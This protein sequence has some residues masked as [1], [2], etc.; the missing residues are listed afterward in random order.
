[1]GSEGRVEGVRFKSVIH[2]RSE[3]VSRVL[4]PVRSVVGVQGSAF[5]LYGLEIEFSRS[6]RRILGFGASCFG[7][8][9]TPVASISSL[10]SGAL[11]DSGF[12]IRVSGFGDS[13]IGDSGMR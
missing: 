5:T 7:I 12:K 1:M 13:K 11:Q 6:G 10:P 8:G 9:G 2:L 3:C 4:A